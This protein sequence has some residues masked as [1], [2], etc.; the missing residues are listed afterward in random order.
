MFWFVS[1]LVSFGACSSAQSVA[2]AKGSSSVIQ[3]KRFPV[4]EYRQ[5]MMNRKS[6]HA[7]FCVI[8]R[9]GCELLRT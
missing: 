3:G 6:G 2:L 9:S 5:S 8:I 4:L 1:L 7:F